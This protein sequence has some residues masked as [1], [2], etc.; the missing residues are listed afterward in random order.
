MYLDNGL[1]KY[2]QLF[3]PATGRCRDIYCQEINHKFNGTTCIPDESK[4]NTNVYKRMSDIDLSLILVISKTNR[5]ENTNPSFSTL[6]NSRMNETCTNDWTK[7]FHDTLQSKFT[8]R[9]FSDISD[10]LNTTCLV[11]C[12][13]FLGIDYERIIKI[14]Y[15]ILDD[16]NED[17]STPATRKIP[18]KNTSTSVQFLNSSSAASISEQLIHNKSVTIS[19]HFTIGDR[20]E[21]SNDT[22]TGLHVVTLLLLASETHYPIDLCETYSFAVET[23]TIVSD[24]NKTRDEF[25]GDP[26]VMYTAKNGELRRRIRPSGEIDYV[27]DVPELEATFEGGDFTYLFMVSTRTQPKEPVKI[28][29]F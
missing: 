28:I 12:L 26:D 20:N 27:V 7:M 22:L 23:L 3:D 16:F 6:L 10:R 13:G 25:C 29:S 17:L 14:R 2:G 15:E 5:N 18:A 19:F 21:T 4:N 11:F 24:K 9:V 8:I 1:C